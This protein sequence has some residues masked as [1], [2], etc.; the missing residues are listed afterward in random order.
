M[1][2]GSFS[3]HSASTGMRLDKA[4][5]LAIGFGLHNAWICTTMYSTHTVF[6]TSFNLPGIR[7][8]SFSLLYLASIIA[9][10]LIMFVAAAFDQKLTKVSRSRMVMGVA[11]LA[12]CA[13]TLLALA[14]SM[15]PQHS[16]VLE[17]CS[18]IVTGFGSAVLMLYWGIA[19]AREKAS[20]IA[21]AGSTAVV[22]GFALN[23]LVLQSIP[24]P[25]GGIASAVI[26]LI[27][28]L[29]LG[30]IT[31]RPR[32]GGQYS[33]NALPTSKMKLGAT[34]IGPIALIGFSLGILK[35]VSVQ[36]TLAGI[37]TPETLVILLLAGSLTI[38]LFALYKL[39]RAKGSYDSFFR[40]TVPAMACASLIA[41]LLVSGN[42]A[43]S[44]L[45]L[46]ITYIFIETLMWVSYAYLA[47]K[48]HLSP[49][50]LFGLSRGMLT[51]S[52]FAGAV[53][54]LY[55]GPWLDQYALGDAGP[56]A[57]TLVLV[58][59]GYALMPRES[60]IV[61]SIVQCPAVRLVSLEL[62]ENLSLL[63][64]RRPSAND[65]ETPARPEPADQG[66]E[67][68]SVP[69]AAPEEAPVSEARRA[70]LQ[71]NEPE[72]PS[73]VGKFSRK[74]RKVA[75]AYL[76]TERETDILFELAKGNGP[77]YI[78][79]KYYISAGTVKTHIRNVYRKLDVHKRNDLLRMIEEFD[80]D[81]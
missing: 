62:E 45:F 24:T 42:S 1:N 8:G 5:A 39:V 79:D 14:S 35:H 3:S 12:T 16:L 36:T 27:E 43:F 44:D 71:K 6:S 47:H 23:T 61:Q 56:I 11:A 20:V 9:F 66:G 60:D 21:I 52:M 73:S 54:A 77:A 19:F 2:G 34:L 38:S 76:L 65:A 40:V 37:V 26:P 70:M 72:T 57:A 18:G 31:P 59:L 28:L 29:I 51:L 75:H 68:P 80:E 30:N 33:F 50:F 15:A 4:T 64:T 67:S 55:A 46:L 22:L 10:G 69:V 25:F 74:V 49:I 13:G 41:S 7:G 58:A 17:C 32:E 81:N 48:M 53:A 78:Q 63:A